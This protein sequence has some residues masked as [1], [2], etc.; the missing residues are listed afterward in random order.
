MRP[1]GKA[2]NWTKRA[3][4][5]LE[6]FLYSFGVYAIPAAVGLITLVALATWEPQYHTAGAMPVGISVLQQD[7]V[8]LEPA[9]ALQAL[10]STAAVPHRDTQ[11]SQAPFW[12]SF[13]ASPSNAD[14]PVAIELPSRHAIEATC[15]DAGSLKRLGSANRVESSGRMDA[16]KAGFALRLGELQS[17]TRIL[18]RST[19][20]GPARISVVQWPEDQ[21]EATVKNRGQLPLWESRADL[22]E[23]D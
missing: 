13:V 14:E 4:A 2:V 18:C 21:L 16:V 12:F 6:A 7:G 9:Q 10:R 3:Q 17:A 8:A 20:S 1:E 19:F 5:A 15:W 22:S 11:L 23:R